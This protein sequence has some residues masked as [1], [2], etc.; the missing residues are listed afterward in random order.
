MFLYLSSLTSLNQHL[1]PI[2][3]I[4]R[5]CLLSFLDIL[6][7]SI[8]EPDCEKDTSK[9]AKAFSLE[10]SEAPIPLWAKS[11]KK[12]VSSRATS[13]LTQGIVQR[14]SKFSY[15]SNFLKILKASAFWSYL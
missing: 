10:R 13:V 11:L 4:E 14:F 8:E 3:K 9:P 7:L 15:N 2:C 1:E 12:I 5:T 6:F